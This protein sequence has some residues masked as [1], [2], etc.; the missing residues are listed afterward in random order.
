MILDSLQAYFINPSHQSA[1]LYVF[2]FI[3]DRQRLRKN[4]PI[5]TRQR[6]CKNIPAAM[7]TRNNGFIFGRVVLY[8]VSVY[9]A[10]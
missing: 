5:V 8:A 7:N 10:K 4:P 1:C 9:E 6:I 2:P 3:V